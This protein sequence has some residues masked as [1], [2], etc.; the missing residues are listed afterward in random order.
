MVAVEV[1]WSDKSFEIVEVLDVVDFEE[2]ENV[3]ETPRLSSTG[4]KA[5]KMTSAGLTAPPIAGDKTPILFRTGGVPFDRGVLWM[6]CNPMT[7]GLSFMT[8]GQTT[9]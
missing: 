6:P 5:R 2:L 8:P 3:C 7:H 9:V 1:C 4:E